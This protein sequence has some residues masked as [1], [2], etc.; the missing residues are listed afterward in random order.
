MSAFDEL[1]RLID[2]AGLTLSFSRWCRSGI[3]GKDKCVCWRCR[4]EDGPS[5]DESA[6]EQAA[7]AI[8]ARRRM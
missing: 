6:A 3:V 8:D 1:Q 7:R 5:D 2:E 4:G